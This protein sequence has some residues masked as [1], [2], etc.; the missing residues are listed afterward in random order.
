VRFCLLLISISGVGCL[1]QITTE[2]IDGTDLRLLVDVN[3]QLRPVD[4]HF[5]EGF[6]GSLP[7]VIAFHGSGSSGGNMRLGSGL[8]AVSDREGFVVAYP[9][10]EIGNWAEDCGCNNADDNRLDDTTFVKVIA[11]TVAGRV[12]LDRSRI[13][14]VGFS[15]GGLF[16]QRLACQMSDRIAAVASVAGSL[17][18]PLSDKCTPAR[19]SSVM[20]M[21]GTADAVFP[22]EGSGQGP[23]EVLGAAAAQARWLDLNICPNP[24]AATMEPDAV[25]DGTTVQKEQAL[26]CR[27]GSEV[28]LYSVENGGH[29][30]TMSADVSTQ[31]LIW[32]FFDRHMLP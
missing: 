11:D 10:A 19:G 15:Q 9:T 32:E 3:R 2:A 24:P 27:D 5:P 20:F 12:T 4:L 16:V 8:N 1:G 22:Y 26:G 25:A 28:L 18:V 30:W 23:L 29:S 31:E 6:D 7:L 17:S 13:Y 21:L 14:A